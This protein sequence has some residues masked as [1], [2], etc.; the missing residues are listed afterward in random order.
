MI[1]FI[2]PEADQA[3]NY[4][5]EP[6]SGQRVRVVN[7]AMVRNTGMCE[8]GGKSR[9]CDHTWEQMWRSWVWVEENEAHLGDFFVKVDDE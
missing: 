5:T 8:K 3:P 6:T 7:I 1:R 9:P 4:Y 2:V